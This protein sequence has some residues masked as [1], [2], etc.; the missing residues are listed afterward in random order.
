MRRSRGGEAGSDAAGKVSSALAQLV[1]RGALTADARQAEAALLLDNIA[2][3]LSQRE[4]QNGLFAGLFQRGNPLKGAYLHGNVGRGKTL[5]MDLFFAEAPLAAKRRV[6]F[7]EFMDEMHAGITKFRNSARG[8]RDDADPIAAVVKPILSKVKLLCLDEFQVNDIT[9]AMLL[10]RLFEKLFAGGVV[11]VAT[12]N[13]APDD[14]YRD[15]LNRE[16]F[17]PFITLLKEYTTVFPLD[18]STDYRRLKFEGQRVYYIGTGAPAKTAMDKLW[19]R[20]TGGVA[21]KPD[22]LHVLGRTIAVPEAAMGVAR[23]AAG[24]LI[25]KPLGARDYL[26]LAHAYDA[27]IIDDVPEFDRTRSNAAKRFIL[28]ID[29]LYDMGV[30]LGASFAVPLDELGHDDKTRAEFARAASRL[31]EMQSA[32]YLAAPR[33]VAIAA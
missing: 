26:R 32:E 28:L 25:D 22:E 23:F 9:N 10:G 20:L 21:G 17:L 4:R 33:K 29:T 31:V 18:G 15:G 13:V 30:K 1:A 3:G 16:L 6:H 2:E 7:H 27:L 19:T 14:L 12:S 11:L 8:K 24:D 5:L